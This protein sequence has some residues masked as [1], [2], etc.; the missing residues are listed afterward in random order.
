MLNIEA[1]QVFTPSDCGQLE[2]GVGAHFTRIGSQGTPQHSPKAF[3]FRQ[4]DFFDY[5]LSPLSLSNVSMVHQFCYGPSQHQPKVHLHCL[6]IPAKSSQT[7]IVFHH[8]Q[9]LIGV[10]LWLLV[11]N[12]Q[13]RYLTPNI[14]YCTSI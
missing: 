14:M 9:H 7:I 13:N 12:D 11:R 5:Q 2:K 10:L 3:K 6:H 8:P 1:R 4:N